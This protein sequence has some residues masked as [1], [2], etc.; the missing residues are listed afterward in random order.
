MMRGEVDQYVK[1]MKDWEE[2]T[3]KVMP[4]TSS[5]GRVPPAG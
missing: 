3:L 4:S 5:D 2:E 1:E